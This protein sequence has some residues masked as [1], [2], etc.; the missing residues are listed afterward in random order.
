MG[1][2]DRRAAVFSDVLVSGILV[3][4][5]EAGNYKAIS[6]FAEL[7]I[8]LTVTFAVLVLIAM[9]V[10]GVRQGFWIPTELWIVLLLFGTFFPAIAF[11]SF[12]DYSSEKVSRLFT[13]TLLAAVASVWLMR[14]R[15]RIRWFLYWLGAVGVALAIFGITQGSDPLVSGGRFVVPGGDP[16]GLGRVAGAAL[17]C[18]GLLAFYRVFPLILALPLCALLVISLFSSGSRGPVLAAGVAVLLLAAAIPGSPLK[19]VVRIGAI[20]VV[21]FAATWYGLSQAPDVAL[22][23]FQLLTGD[24]LGL[25]IYTRE[26]M[27]GESIALI[28]ETP[29]GLGWGDFTEQIVIAA[30]AL[31]IYPH[32]ILLEVTLEGGWLAGAALLLVLFVAFKRSARR[33]DHVEGAALFGL[34]AYVTAN[35]MVSGDVNSNRMVF[36]LAAASLAYDH[37]RAAEPRQLPANLP[38]TVVR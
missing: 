5:L 30:P 36:T 29:L 12:S 10:V 35:A 21:A 24:D 14:T 18:I 16:I 9:T 25:S 6:L 7:P 37:V 22:A 27:I 28:P 1:Q 23:R 34:I 2:D 4:F 20:G 33:L 3:L 19:R 8:D 15:S 26:L 11:S 31:E 38:S 17:V 32:N 13:L